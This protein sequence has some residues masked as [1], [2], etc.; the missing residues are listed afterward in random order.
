MQDVYIGLKALTIVVGVFALS[1]IVSIKTKGILSIMLVS[2]IIFIIAFANGLSPTIFESSN[3]YQLGSLLVSVLIVHLGTTLNISTLQKQWKVILVA[4]S[5]EIGIVFFVIGFGSFFYDSDIVFSAIPP[6]GGGI[7]AT[8]M[9]H[10]V[11]ETQNLEQIIIFTTLLLSFSSFV[12]YPIASFLLKKE[13]KDR[14]KRFKISQFK[15]IHEPEIS[16]IELKFLRIF[17]AKYDS[18]TIVLSKIIATAFLSFFVAKL[19]NNIINE[20][21]V[22]LFLGFLFK[23]IGFLEFDSLNKA[24]SYGFTVVSVLSV[25]FQPFNSISLHHILITLVPLLFFLFLGILGMVIMSFWVGKK[26]KFS[27]YL[28]IS[29][30]ISCLFGFPGTYIIPHEVARSVG[31]TKEEQEFILENIYP[32]MLI[33]GFVNVTISS[34][35]IASLLVRF[36]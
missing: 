7:V 27:K 34:V 1:E 31:K 24:N 35:I 16:V 15:K 30:G 8:L 6:I 33:A 26:L 21:V 22:C 12:G 10:K 2:S 11:A 25:I 3:L 17:F 28:S 23:E 19:T 20:Y 9:V 4:I 18:P 13:A 29:I 14:M 36:I 5:A 32:Q